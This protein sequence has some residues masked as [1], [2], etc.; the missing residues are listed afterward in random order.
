MAQ[1]V[2]RNIDAA[3]KERLR[4][5]AKRNGRSMEEE[6]RQILNLA[7][8]AEDRRQ[9]KLSERIAARFKNTGP[10]EVVELRGYRVKPARF[11]E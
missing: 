1:L 8:R 11:D 10:L 5:R 3:V 6:V 4:R 9:G 2:V 7:V